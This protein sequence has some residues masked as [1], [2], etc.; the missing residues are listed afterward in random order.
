MQS[1]QKV[2]VRLG[3]RSYAIIV[4]R[5]ILS[6]LGEQLALLGFSPKIGIVSN[7]TVFRLY[8]KA[9]E[10]SLRNAGFEPFPV[11]IPDGE[12]YKTLKYAEK[13]L[14]KLL[15]ERLD[16]KACLIAL[17][18]GVIGDVSGFAASLYMRGISFVQVPTTLLSQVDSSVGGKTGV[19]HPL[20]KNMIGAFY[21]PR[22]VW[23]D[24]DTLKTLPRRELL[25]GVAEVI[26][27]GVIWDERFF[28]FLEQMREE[29][30]GLNPDVL[31]KVIRT[32]CSI[33]AQVVSKDEREGGLRAI[34]NFGHTV[35][36]AIETETRYQQF[37]HGEAVA[38]GMHMEAIL[39]NRLKLLEKSSVSRIRKLIASYGLP[40]D[41]PEELDAERLCLHMKIDKKAE[42]GRVVFVLP[43]RIGAVRIEKNVDLKTVSAVL[44]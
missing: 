33:K 17:G 42:S 3:K 28:A 11:I 21:Q 12:K 1:L 35:G 22:L 43:E 14:T 32:S 36:H 10:Q 4:G 2:Q 20:G 26:K 13:I 29:L 37:L 23:I 41:I 9:V 6:Q 34:L 25:C 39:A 38:I 8:G 5:G 7:P 31:S 18:G 30:L 19:N 27:Y 40:A 15:Q 24:T 44:S 16:R